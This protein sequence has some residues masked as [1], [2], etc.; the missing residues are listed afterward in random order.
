MK[1]IRHYLIFL[2]AAIPAM[3]GS[4][5]GQIPMPAATGRIPIPQPST[6]ALPPAPQRAKIPRQVTLDAAEE[7]LLQNNLTIVAARYGVDI[8]RAQRLVASL[9]PN[10]VLTFSSELFYPRHPGQFFVRTNSYST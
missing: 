1:R 2:I 8:A 4:T 9:H 6:A 3:A 5:P 10:P 7:I